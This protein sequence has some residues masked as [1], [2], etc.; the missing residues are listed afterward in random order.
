MSTPEIVIVD[1]SQ[2]RVAFF[3]SI[4]MDVGCTCH[5]L[6]EW[7]EAEELLI[8]RI[9]LPS[10]VIVGFEA[11][12][13]GGLDTV[14]NANKVI[15]GLGVPSVLVYGHSVAAEVE[16]I[17]TFCEYAAHLELPGERSDVVGVLTDLLP[18]VDFGDSVL[19]EGIPEL[20]SAPLQSVSSWVDLE[21]LVEDHRDTRVVVTMPSLSSGSLREVPLPRLLYF[22]TMQRRTGVLSVRNGP[23]VHRAAFNNGGLLAEQED[24]R[25]LKALQ[26][27]FAWTE[28]EYYFKWERVLGGQQVPL[29]HYIFEGLRNVSMNSA[30]ERLALFEQGYLAH[31][32][33]FFVRL[34]QI[35]NLGQVTEVARLC[36]GE[37]SLSDLLREGAIDIQNM[38]TS[39]NFCLSTDL[40]TILEKPALV[41]VG[42]SYKLHNRLGDMGGGHISELPHA[43]NEVGGGFGRQ[44]YT[45]AQISRLDP[46]LAK[47][48]A[49]LEEML[50]TLLERDAY[51]VFDL[52]AG[53]GRQAVRAAYQKLR[54]RLPS[55]PAGVPAPIWMTTQLLDTALRDSYVLLM[56]Q[57]TEELGERERKDNSGRFLREGT[58][59]T[60]A[61]HSLMADWEVK[62]GELAS[63]DPYEAF[64]LWKGCG[65]KL[66]IKAYQALEE[67]Y[68]PNRAHELN[69]P[70]VV[71][72]MNSIYCALKD[73]LDQLL[74]SEK[75]KDPSTERPADLDTDVLR[76]NT[77]L[78]QLACAERRQVGT[79]EAAKTVSHSLAPR[80]PQ[81]RAAKKSTPVLEPV[82]RDLGPK[83]Y[84]ASV[85]KAPL[86]TRTRMPAPDELSTSQIP[87]TP[88]V[89]QT[90]PS[91]L[92]KRSSSA[93][94]AIAH[95]S[96]DHFRQGM[97]C[98]QNKAN[99]AAHAHFKEAF[100]GDKENGKYKAYLAW[101]SFLLS[102]ANLDRTRTELKQ[103]KKLDGG[104]EAASFFLGIIDLNQGELATAEKHL[105]IAQRENA[106]NHEVRRALRL[107]KARQSADQKGSILKSFFKS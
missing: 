83:A 4:F 103:A 68:G 77:V 54:E 45:A 87:E 101:A 11:L 15:V 56:A 74:V 29:Y 8:G 97:L 90:S 13:T 42:L 46:T 51:E 57:E 19:A 43:V 102:P 105:K 12:A 44:N 28:G 25:T 35:K 40:V 48:L 7:Q 88:A 24:S 107:V 50:K 78:E 84:K 27:A 47:E 63:E 106:N 71:N 73:V 67:Q 33:L 79:P 10:L 5:V 91:P 18:S 30:L 75:T 55:S 20:P 95:T 89:E 26:S 58:G 31:T 17:K 92:P 99:E 21:Q 32:T 9:L 16:F 98:L 66:I 22:L 23:K 94:L 53:C 85:P 1:L 104:V 3:E 61:E 93:V 52:F 100:A 96:E 41:P 64:D 82:S 86:Q 60:R 49:G 14:W 36:K 81:V 2:E 39:L 76:L 72:A 38:L 6:N 34:K 59:L 69:H 70:D 80:S 62:L 65:R 37:K